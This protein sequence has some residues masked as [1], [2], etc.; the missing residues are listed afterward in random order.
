M[1]EKIFSTFVMSETT[2]NQIKALPYAMQLKFFWAVTDYGID[3]IEPEFDGLELAV[4]IPMRDL[5]N[6]AKAKD[7][8][9]HEKQRQ[10][11]KKGGR[12]K[13]QN[14]P[15][16][17]NETQNNP[18][19]IWVSEE[20]HNDN[21]NENEKG[22]EF[23]DEKCSGP[24]EEPSDGHSFSTAQAVVANTPVLTPGNLPAPQNELSAFSPVDS[25]P[26]RRKKLELT[27]EQN[28]LYHAAKACFELSDKARAIIYQDEPSAKM[29]MNK[30]KEIVVRC[31][32]IAPGITVDFLKNVLDHFRVMANSAKYKGSWVFTP[33]CLSTH[34]I[35]EIVISS[36]PEQE[37]ELDKNI[38]ESIKGL[39]KKRVRND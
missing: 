22:K 16:K 29:Q 4:W 10:N 17:A 36:L 21:D 28:A 11:G 3:A 34:W 31:S 14:N 1:A 7:E 38:H 35:W 26:K 20:S 33:R 13:T 39:F 6:S 19:G 25:P 27:P 18:D 15:D 12:P 5:I 9:W 23:N 37:T 32:N 2:R 8:A 30:L 24:P